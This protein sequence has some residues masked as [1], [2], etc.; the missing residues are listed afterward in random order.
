MAFPVWIQMS[1]RARTIGKWIF[2]FFFFFFYL[3]HSVGVDLGG[4]R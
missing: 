4:L 2:V 3:R 1:V